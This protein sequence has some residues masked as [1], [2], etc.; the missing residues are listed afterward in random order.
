MSIERSVLWKNRKD[1][2]AV[3]LVS[4]LYD[5]NLQLSSRNE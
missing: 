2:M 4:I 1:L 5:R 3:A